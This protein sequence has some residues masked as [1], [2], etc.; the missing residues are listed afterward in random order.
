MIRSLSKETYKECGILAYQRDLQRVLKE[1]GQE[2]L[3]DI[4]KKFT[5]K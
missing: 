3:Q 2:N 1:S 4:G 5:L